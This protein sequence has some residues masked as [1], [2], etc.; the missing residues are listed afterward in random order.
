MNN[1]NLKLTN[2]RNRDVQFS[3]KLKYSKYWIW[4]NTVENCPLLNNWLTEFYYDYNKRQKLK[5]GIDMGMTGVEALKD[6][7]NN[8]F[9]YLSNSQKR[10][11]GA[12]IAL[13]ASEMGYVPEISAPV[14]NVINI[15]T[16]STYR[17]K[18]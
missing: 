4:E 6:D 13:I 2:D 8:T 11:L 12:S 15:K 17:R 3:D 9:E 16:A 1:K 18:I 10:C 14:Y 7:I 5:D